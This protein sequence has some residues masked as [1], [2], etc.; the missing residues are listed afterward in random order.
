MAG[1]TAIETNAGTVTVVLPLIPLRVA[2][3]VVEPAPWA[4]TMPVLL[5]VATEVFV[6]VHVA[7]VVMFCVPPPW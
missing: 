6:E 2:V 4:V 5:T 1:V 7:C 3:I